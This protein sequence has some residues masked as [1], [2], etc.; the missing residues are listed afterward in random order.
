MGDKRTR[1]VIFIGVCLFSIALL[2]IV[3]RSHSSHSDMQKSVA[4]LQKTIT[5]SDSAT[6]KS[7]ADLQKTITQLR[8]DNEKLQTQLREDNEKLQ[9]NISRSSVEILRDFAI[10]HSNIAPDNYEIMDEAL[11]KF[12]PRMQRYLAIIPTI[13]GDAVTAYAQTSS[14][15]PPQYVHS[16]VARDWDNTFGES[17]YWEIY[18]KRGANPNDPV[19]SRA[20]KLEL[21]VHEYLHHAERKAN[22]DLAKFFEDVNAWYNDPSW[23]RATPE[24]NYQKYRL[25]WNVYGKNGFPS[26]QPP[27]R[28]EFAYIGE[29]IANRGRERLKELPQN[30]IAYYRGILREDL[31]TPVE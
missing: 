24:G 10:L 15:E 21:Y 14:Y 13:I 20:F 29:E 7:V 4:D 9:T 30:I 12:D 5:Q 18:K 2:L 19:F 16:V 31:L 11:E 26:H 8:E 1:R 22:L 6:Q 17:V 27:G 28:E 23:G 3:Y 25:F